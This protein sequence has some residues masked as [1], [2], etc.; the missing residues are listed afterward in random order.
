MTATLPPTVVH[1]LYV[2]AADQAR[3]LTDMQRRAD[4]YVR[5]LRSDDAVEAYELERARIRA[6]DGLE[7]VPLTSRGRTVMAAR[8]EV[9][10]DGYLVL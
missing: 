10:A 6:E 8:H 3:Q 1:V 2:D 5:R 9:S 7:P 4:E